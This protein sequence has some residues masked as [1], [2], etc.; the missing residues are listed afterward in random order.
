M[1]SSAPTVLPDAVAG[2][3]GPSTKSAHPTTGH[4]GSP[5]QSESAQSARP[6]PS[7]STPLAQLP[8]SDGGAQSGSATQSKSKQSVAPSASSS[9]PLPHTSAAA[10]PVTSRT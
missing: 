9:A 10:G 7:S 8:A 2:W 6:S 1:V 5:A 4:A 3:P